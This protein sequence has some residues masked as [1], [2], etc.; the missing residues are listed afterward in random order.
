MNRTKLGVGIG[1]LSTL[2]LASSAE[3]LT[4]VPCSTRV[5]H[6][7]GW[8][9]PLPNTYQIKK[10]DTLWGIA[11][12]QLGNPFAYKQVADMNGILNSDIIFP[13]QKLILPERNVKKRNYTVSTMVSDM[14]DVCSIHE[15][16]YIRSLSH[17]LGTPIFQ[18]HDTVRYDIDLV[19]HVVKQ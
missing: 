4:L 9:E 5:D 15:P 14:G 2:L 13:G 1:A 18:M 7:I 17:P 19:R 12:E 11:A 6:Y 16:V 3:S 10:N 8:E